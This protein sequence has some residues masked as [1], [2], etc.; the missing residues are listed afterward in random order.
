VTVEDAAVFLGRLDGGAIATYE[1]THF[2]TGRKNAIRLELHGE[3][4]SLAFDLER[5]SEL[6]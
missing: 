6:E 5:L 2:A 4:G 3:Q 1:A